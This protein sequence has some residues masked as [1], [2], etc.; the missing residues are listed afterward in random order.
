MIHNAAAVRRYAAALYAAASAAGNVDRVADDLHLVASALHEHPKLRDAL[1]Q[2]VTPDRA[3]RAVVQKLFGERL[4]P[5]TLQFLLLLIEKRRERI[6]LNAEAAFRKIADERQGVVRAQVI[7]AVELSG[8]EREQLRDLLARRTGR[9]VII[10]PQVDPGILGGLVVRI[11]DRLLDG[12]V[13]AEI[14]RLRQ[15]LAGREE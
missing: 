10:E 7:A 6:A 12:S 1:V 15:A 9:Q 2:R 3:K 14:R 4:D 11:G 8:A 13:K 5:L